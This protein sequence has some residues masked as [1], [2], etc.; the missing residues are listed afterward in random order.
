MA[1]KI[2]IYVMSRR[3][4]VFKVEKKGE[5][6]ESVAMGVHVGLFGKTLISGLSACFLTSDSLGEKEYSFPDTNKQQ[7]SN[8]DS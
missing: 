7:R 3:K 8:Y 4:N 5:R 1:F 2:H 6:K